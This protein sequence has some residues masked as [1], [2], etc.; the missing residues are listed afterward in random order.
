MWRPV[1]RIVAQHAGSRDLEIQ[2]RSC[3][4]G[5]LFRFDA[6]RPQLLEPMPALDEATYMARFNAPAVVATGPTLTGV[7]RSCCTLR[8]SPTLRHTQ[9]CLFSTRPY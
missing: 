9:A 7:S 6:L 8:H 3:E 5:R 2:S 4:F 1:Q